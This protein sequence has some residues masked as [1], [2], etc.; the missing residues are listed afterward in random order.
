MGDENKMAREADTKHKHAR[1]TNPE[2]G[3]SIWGKEVSPYVSS[4]RT[5]DLT[6]KNNEKKKSG[7]NNTLDVRKY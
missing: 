7:R 2:S 1:K 3:A 4:V 5:L 6:K